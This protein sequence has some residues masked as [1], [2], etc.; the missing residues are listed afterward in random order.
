[1][2]GPALGL[3]QRIDIVVECLRW[4]VV[5]LIQTLK[6]LE[7][8]MVKFVMQVKPSVREVEADG[9]EILLKVAPKSALVAAEMLLLAV[10]KP[11]VVQE[12]TVTLQ[13]LPMV[14]NE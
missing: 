10:L 14:A 1:M 13:H 4:F 3:V 9:Y 11:W 2:I 7:Q 8:L 6:L 12:L 5:Q